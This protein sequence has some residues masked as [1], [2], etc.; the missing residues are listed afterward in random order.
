MEV[1]PDFLGIRGKKKS[2]IVLNAYARHVRRHFRKA[3][4][5]NNTNIVMSYL[6]ETDFPAELFFALIDFI[7]PMVY[8]DIYN[9]HNQLLFEFKRPHCS[10]NI[11]SELSIYRGSGFYLSCLYWSSGMLM[12]QRVRERSHHP[13]IRRCNTC[14][15]SGQG[16]QKCARCL[17]TYYC[18][19]RCQKRDWHTHKSRCRC[20][21]IEGLQSCL[22]RLSDA[23]F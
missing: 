19:V 18:S 3:I 23:D 14:F 21:P 12:Q 16:L 9:R 10:F 13:H 4:M 8:C 2:T 11:P 6:T 17:V 1:H 20:Y 5:L 15:V 22:T 7:P